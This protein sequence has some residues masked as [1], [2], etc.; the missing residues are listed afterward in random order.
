MELGPLGPRSTAGRSL[1]HQLFPGRR[2]GHQ[3]LLFATT[4]YWEKPE[5]T[6]KRDGGF[7][8]IAVASK[9]RWRKEGCVCVCVCVRFS[10]WYLVS[11]P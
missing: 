11:S 5:G 2:L 8:Y 6:P 7:Y 3:S 10:L 4:V 1:Y 9:P